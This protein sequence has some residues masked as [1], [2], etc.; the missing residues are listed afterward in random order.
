[1]TT[2]DFLDR[3]VDVYGNEVGVI[4]HDG[5]EYTYA[6]F[7]QRVDRAAAALS[8]LGIEQGD[9]V[10]LLSPNTHWFLE[11]LFA[12]NVLGAV[13]VPLNYR[14][15]AADYE[16]ILGDCGARAVVADHEYAETVEEIRDAV[17]VE[18]FVANSADRVDGEWRDYESLLEDADPAAVERP[19]ISED[20]PA[21][22]NYTSGTTGDPKGVVRTHRTEHWHALI[23]TH[24]TE[25]TDDD[26]YLWTLPMFHVNGW[27]YPYI[28]TGVGGT[29]VCQRH[30][31]AGGAFERIQD[32]NV[33]YLCGA[34][35]VLDRMLNHYETHDVAATGDKPVRIA[36]AASPPPEATI[37]TVEDELGWNI[38]HVYGLTETGPLI[39]TSN[40]PRRIASEGRFTIK[41]R[42]GHA[43]VG[44][45]LRVVDEDGEDVPADDETMG[46]IVVRGNQVMDRYWNKP[47]Q[48]RE[49]FS[50]RAEGW[51]HTGDFATVDDRRM[52]SIKDRKKDV[53]ISGGE[54]ISSVE[55]EDALY[56]HPDIERVAVIGVPHEKWGETPKALV[57]P[58]AGADLTE[59]AVVAFARDT[60]AHFKCPTVVEFVDDL[61]ETSTG[62]IRKVELRESHAASA[63]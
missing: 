35:T 32:H 33:T 56:N 16:Y 61:P 19:G 26:A 60:L 54:N 42:Q 20:D 27:G 5:T 15:I 62:K 44:T 4:A 36:T 31:D 7:G 10:A 28:V 11:T 40:S 13:S 8:D 59:D 38:L 12:I 3:G 1:M 37:R 48:T 46:E 57:V 23:S 49:A 53:I 17:P 22:I 58:A 24:H 34:P 52:I 18:T 39:T 47:E 41:T 50:G 6:E 51:F 29:H 21:T 55:V 30:F 43:M 14:L 2:L 45:E 63:E 9:R 25:V